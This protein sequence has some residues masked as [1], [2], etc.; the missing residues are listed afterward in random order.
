MLF[1]IKIDNY[2]LLEIYS[3]QLALPR[4]DQVSEHLQPVKFH[5]ELKNVEISH[6]TET[7]MTITSKKVNSQNMRY[8]CFNRRL[9]ISEKRNLFRRD[10]EVVVFLE[11]G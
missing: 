11:D 9:S 3:I 7:N 6:I 1:I 4:V 10:E 5:K 8:V 2:K